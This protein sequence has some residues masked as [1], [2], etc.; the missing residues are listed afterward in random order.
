MHRSVHLSGCCDNIRKLESLESLLGKHQLAKAPDLEARLTLWAQKEVLRPLHAAHAVLT[1]MLHQE[2]RHY[3]HCNAAMEPQNVT[4]N[5]SP[6]QT[7]PHED[8]ET[9]PVLKLPAGRGSSCKG[10]QARGKGCS[11]PHSPPGA[12]GSPQGAAPPRVCYLSQFPMLRCIY[13]DPSYCLSHLA[14]S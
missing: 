12:E 3:L 4:K 5:G 14:V 2:E 10:G 9:P 6:A 11:K 13:A 1:G 8:K 7:C